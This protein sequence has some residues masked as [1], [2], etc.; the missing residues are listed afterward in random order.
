[1]ENNVQ[2]TV[3]DLIK[4]RYEELDELTKKGVETFAYSF[5]VNSDSQK[6]KSKFKEGT[7]MNVRIAGRIMAI[8]RMGKAS[9]AHIQDH[10]RKNTSLS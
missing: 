10:T 4:R 6:I 5:D 1:M 7:E 3:N 2:P 9:F 8:R